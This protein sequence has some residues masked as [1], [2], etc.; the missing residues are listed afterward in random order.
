MNYDISTINAN[1]SLLD[2]IG[3]V[4]SLTDNNR[5]FID[6]KCTQ[7]IEAFSNYRWDA[8]ENLIKE[9][10]VH[11]EYSH[12]ADAIRY[13]CYSHSYNMDS[14]SFEIEEEDNAD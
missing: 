1:K 11:D 8:R 3:Y 14:L 10:P 7:T 12:P 4:A 13:A 6:K 5:L 2:G 9:K